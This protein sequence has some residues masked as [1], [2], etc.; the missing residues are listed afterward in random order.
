L[1][2]GVYPEP[3]QA[4]SIPEA[5]VQRIIQM[6]GD[7]EWKAGDQ[8]PAQRQLAQAL[9]V[10]TGS[11]REA[12]QTLQ[13]MGVLE[14][15]HGQGT[16]VCHNPSQI[17]ER[18]LNLAIV[19]DRDRVEDFL[20]ARRAIEGGL[21]YLAARRASPEQVAQ[22]TD[23]VAGMKKAVTTGNDAAFE[24]LDITFHRLITEM[25]NSDILQYL[26]ST[27]FETL[28]EFIRVVPHTPKGC[29]AHAK[30]CAAIQ[31]QDPRRSEQAMHDL[32]DATAAYVLFL[33]SRQSEE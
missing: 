16:F 23:L 15:R 3:I 12:L 24:A 9:G 13:G 6:I 22:L 31:A 17:V 25:S 18:C 5:I 14:L 11:L 21:A 10:S 19:L 29:Q 33:Q 32:V 28:E 8:L 2:F 7:G 30:V 27:L 20:D 4:P 26:G 1:D